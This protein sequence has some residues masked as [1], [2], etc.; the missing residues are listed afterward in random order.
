MV[1]KLTVSRIEG[2]TLRVCHG[3]RKGERERE[4]EREREGE[5]ER[6][7]ITYIPRGLGFVY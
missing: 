2:G 3:E 6:D 4:R 7:I 1:P 5:R